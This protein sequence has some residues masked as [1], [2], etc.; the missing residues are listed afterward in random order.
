[1]DYTVPFLT[2]WE[3]D[4]VHF[5]A[6]DSKIALFNKYRFKLLDFFAGT[7]IL[8]VL[9]KLQ[10]EQYLP[11]NLQ[12]GNAQNRL[13]ALFKIAQE[14]T[15]FYAD[16]TNYNDLPILT[17]DLIRTVPQ[18][19]LSNSFKGKLF[20]KST[21][22]STGEP[23]RYFTTRL[24]RSYMWAGILLSWQSAGYQLG[25]KVA[26]IAGTSLCKSGYQHS[27]FYRLMNID[28]YSA[29][30]LDPTTIQTYIDRIIRSEVRIIYGYASA[31]NIVSSYV[32]SKGG[33]SFPNLR[34]IVSTAEVLTDSMRQHIKE[35]FNVE[36]FNQ[37]GCNE[38]GVS[39]FE[40][41]HHRI[42]LISSRCFY[43]TDKSGQLIGTDLSNRGFIM[44]KYGTGDIVT[45][46]EDSHCPCSR[47]YPIIKHVVGRTFD[48]ISDMKNNILHSAFFTILFRN[49]PTI[50]Q[51]QIQY[52]TTHIK[53][54]LRTSSGD[55]N[56]AVYDKY[57]NIIK[58]HLCFDRYEI[59]LNTPFLLSQNAK[60]RHIVF[61]TP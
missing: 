25:E 5:L 11:A 42:H 30:H 56:S 21:G 22:G 9:K 29:Y 50:L 59:V 37:Y 2:E 47:T 60:H 45:F 61:V 52:S 31:I 39:A 3:K 57:L 16:Y 58:S 36:V 15:S 33:I 1:M 20:T 7:S 34:A 55:T 48:I 8:P 28:V 44:M 26:F 41:E 54:F 35:A 6:R 18:S 53:I 14:S 19:F 51:F 49:D 10:I 40:C 32:K 43:E 17:K 12:K 23:L 13:D 4:R 46:S 27:L 38:A 24:S